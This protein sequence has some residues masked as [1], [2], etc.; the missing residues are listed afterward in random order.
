M[1]NPREGESGAKRI[2]VMLKAFMLT[3]LALS[4]FE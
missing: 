4:P 1:I 3:D 2:L